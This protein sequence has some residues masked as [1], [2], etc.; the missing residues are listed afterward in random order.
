MVWYTAWVAHDI[1]P[2]RRDH[3]QRERFSV[4]NHRGRMREQISTKAMYTLQMSVNITSTCHI[5]RSFLLMAKQPSASKLLLRRLVSV[6]STKKKKAGWG[7]HGL[8]SQPCEIVL[9]FPLFG[10]LI[11]SGIIIAT[12]A[13][14]CIWLANWRVS[15]NL[16]FYFIALS[17]QIVYSWEHWPSGYENEK[18]NPLLI[19]LVS[20]V[21]IL[22]FN[23]NATFLIF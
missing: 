3:A 22:N 17:K 5:S 20:S 15:C 9:K 16:H 8:S 1:R 10:A 4:S 11:H 19:Y 6:H 18:R 23:K 14:I 7:N 12:V 2:L 13:H 21:H